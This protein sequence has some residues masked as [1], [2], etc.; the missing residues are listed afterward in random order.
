MYQEPSCS[1]LSFGELGEYKKVWDALF[2]NTLLLERCREKQIYFTIIGSIKSDQ[3]LAIQRKNHYLTLIITNDSKLS[4]SAAGK[5]TFFESLQQPHIYREEDFEIDF[6]VSKY[7]L[8]IHH[9]NCSGLHRT[10]LTDPQLTIHDEYDSGNVLT[11]ST[12][13]NTY[14]ESCKYMD[15]AFPGPIIEHIFSRKY[16]SYQLELVIAGQKRY[17]ELLPS[18]RSQRIRDRGFFI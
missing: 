15:T 4:L 13:A 7:T 11:L 9:L 1:H 16:N 10:I 12:C 17:I 8:N 18:S 6:P 3:P 5:T 14:G 2:C